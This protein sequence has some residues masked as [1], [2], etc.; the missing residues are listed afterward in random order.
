MSYSYT[1]LAA[2]VMAFPSLSG[3]PSNPCQTAGVR[4]PYLPEPTH[5]ALVISCSF[6]RR[7]KCVSSRQLYLLVRLR[8]HFQTDHSHFYILAGP[9]LGLVSALRTTMVLEERLIPLNSLFLSVLSCA[10]RLLA[11]LYALFLS[12]HSCTLSCSCCAHF[13]SHLTPQTLDRT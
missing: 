6:I 11:L 4:S 9:K 5:V 8:A 1:G 13:I 10:S 3:F 7:A 12:F 2:V